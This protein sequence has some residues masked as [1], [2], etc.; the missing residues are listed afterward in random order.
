MPIKSMIDPNI[1]VKEVNKLFAK[2]KLVLSPHGLIFKACKKLGGKKVTVGKM[3]EA[4]YTK[5]VGTMFDNADARLEN[6]D[7][8]VDGQRISIDWYDE[9]KIRLI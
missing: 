2:D 3:T 1:L 4:F 5:N 9:T 6:M 8:N 7:I